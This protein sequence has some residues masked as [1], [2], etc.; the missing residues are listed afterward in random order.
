LY[1]SWKS[2]RRYILTYLNNAR[3]DCRPHITVQIMAKQLSWP[4]QS[5]LDSP[6]GQPSNRNNADIIAHHVRTAQGGKIRGQNQLEFHDFPSSR[7]D[8][9]SDDPQK[10]STNV[11]RQLRASWPPSCSILLIVFGW[12]MP[13]TPEKRWFGGYFLQ[14]QTRQKVATEQRQNRAKPSRSG[15]AGHLSAIGVSS[16]K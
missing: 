9:N 7:V 11:A 6:R 8:K 10:R 12:G 4:L 13:Q 5:S 16:I 14:L 2:G 3:Q 15:S 1:V